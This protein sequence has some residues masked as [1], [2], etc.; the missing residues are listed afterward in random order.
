MCKDLMHVAIY[1]MMCASHYC[2]FHLLQS[3]PTIGASSVTVFTLSDSLYAVVGSLTDTRSQLYQ[4]RNGGFRLDNHFDSSSV[5]DVVFLPPSGLAVASSTLQLLEWSAVSQ[6]FVPSGTLNALQPLKLELF[7]DQLFVANVNSPSQI[8]QFQNG[9]WIESNVSLPVSR[10]LYPFTID[11]TF[12]L[13]SAGSTR[14][15]VMEMLQIDSTVTD[16][17]YRQVNLTFAPDEAILRF[18]VRIV[19]DDIPEVDESF[20]VVLSNPV[21]G[22]SI[23]D[24]G[25]VTMVILTNDD[26]HGLIGFAEV[27]RDKNIARIIICVNIIIM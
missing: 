27:L 26:A 20:S 3:L 13:A 12:Y 1:C 16:Y 18:S 11:S 9:M 15:V 25:A 24:N 21:G 19:N 7:S 14:S 23:G 5:R 2:L 6:T 22:A 4:W 17:F 10:H 8:F